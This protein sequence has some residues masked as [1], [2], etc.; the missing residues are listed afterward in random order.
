MWIS[1]YVQTLQ[2]SLS[3]LSPATFNFLED[4][5]AAECSILL[6]QSC[7]MHSCIPRALEAPWKHNLGYAWPW[8]QCLLEVCALA[9]LF[10]SPWSSPCLLP[11]L[12]GSFF[13]L[14]LMPFLVYFLI[15]VEHILQ[16]FLE[17]GMRK[18]NS[19]RLYAWDGL[20][21]TSNLIKNWAADR[22]SQLHLVQVPE[23]RVSL[24]QF[25]RK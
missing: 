9:T 7:L 18:T 15:S 19:L 16:E 23:S 2:E 24:V 6:L 17:K 1:Q 14:G 8:E 20:Y 10:A 21:S 11:S 5:A 3:L 4:I 12:V 22:I 25:S 13:F